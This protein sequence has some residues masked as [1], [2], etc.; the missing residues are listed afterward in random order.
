MCRTWH[1][2][3]ETQQQWDRPPWVRACKGPER[4]WAWPTSSLIPASCFASTRVHMDHAW[5]QR[6]VGET[7]RGVPV[8]PE[9]SAPGSTERVA[10]WEQHPSAV[11]GV[12]QV[13]AGPF[14]PN[15]R[16]VP[17]PGLPSSA[18]R[19]PAAFCQ[20]GHS[21]NPNPS[22]RGHGWRVRGGRAVPWLLPGAWGHFQLWPGEAFARGGPRSGTDS[23]SC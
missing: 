15:G 10:V 8:A 17:R 21:P 22:T 14:L 7:E 19:G 11:L 9:T 4:R 5:V 2:G 13:W 16:C 18:T 6:G 20:Q 3:E 1:R 23:G 12:P